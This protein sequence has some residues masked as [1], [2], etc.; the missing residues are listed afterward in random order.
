[1]TLSKLSRR[2]D[3]MKP[4][5]IVSIPCE[6]VPSPSKR[7][8]DL[9]AAAGNNTGNL[10]F[11]NAVWEQIAG[12]KQ[13]I[14]FSFRPEKINQELRALVFPAANW[15]GAHV[16]FA[17]LADLV[18]QVDIPVVLIGL[19]AQDDTYSG[20][21][22]VPEGTVRFVRVVAERS[23]SISVRGAYTKK[24]LAKH[25]IHNVVITGCP[26]LYP[27]DSVESD[28]KLLRTAARRS[29]SILLHSTRYSARHRS[30]IEKETLHRE[31]FR[32]AF[33]TR[34]DLLFQSEPEEISLLIDAADKPEM[35]HTLKTALTD[36]YQAG[37]WAG[38]E[39]YIKSYG[40][41]F[42]NI[43]AWSSWVEQYTGS[44]GT[45]LHAT[46]MAL[47]AGTPAVLACHDSRTQEVSD[48]A[49]IPNLPADTALSSLDRVGT[50]FSQTDQE[51]FVMNRNRNRAHYN[52][53]LSDNAL[54]P[55]IA[56]N[57]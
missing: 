22:S 5:G 16:D 18:E 20:E 36:I 7:F 11:T 13:R 53:F 15:F 21:V 4:I 38:L 27:L 26:S 55:V 45:R 2:V 43:R 41:V 50:L 56:A 39:S 23:H 49:G 28:R 52:Q 37:S 14:G 57:A 29:G 48:F 10:L 44:F 9:M 35:D 51:G 40:R 47:N 34:T 24:I 46:I 19:G 12:P 17:S 3:E 8:D 54:A 33:R 1:M 31:I 32:L 42:F 6:Q 30:F 25:G